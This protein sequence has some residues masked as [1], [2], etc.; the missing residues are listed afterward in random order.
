MEPIPQIPNG[1]QQSD[2]NRSLGAQCLNLHA[3]GEQ[4]I[5]KVTD[6]GMV[7]T[8]TQEY[9]EGKHLNSKPTFGVGRQ[10]LGSGGVR[11][12]WQKPNMT[13]EKHF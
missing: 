8:T 3:L 4:W 6:V 13:Y 7:R 9:L 5:E 11:A 1:H 12:C 2:S 10:G